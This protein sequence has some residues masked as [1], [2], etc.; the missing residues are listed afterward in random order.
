MFLFFTK[1]MIQSRHIA[2]KEK[3]LSIV[4]IETINSG[5]KVKNARGIRDILYKKGQ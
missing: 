5:M 3:F 4:N 1:K 2:G